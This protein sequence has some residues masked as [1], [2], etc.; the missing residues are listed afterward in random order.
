MQR[1]LL[2][3]IVLASLLP[4]I[5][6]SA[7]KIEFAEGQLHA[8][9]RK[10]MVEGDRKGAIALY[11]QVLASAMG[12]RA[13]AARALIRLGQCYE[14]LGNAEARKAYERVVKEFSDQKDASEAQ[15]LLAALGGGADRETV[16]RI[17]YSA[18]GAYGGRNSRDGRYVAFEC[19]RAICLLETATGSIR[20]VVPEPKPSARHWQPLPSPDGNWVAYTHFPNHALEGKGDLHV[21]RTDGS[22]DRTLITGD[23]KL[24]DYF[25]PVDW[26]ADSKTILTA[27]TNEKW[28]GLMLVPVAVGPVK[29]LV[30]P[31]F[32][33]FAGRDSAKF[34]PGGE[35]IAY[36]SAKPENRRPGSTETDVNVMPASGGETWPVLA[37]K[38]RDEVVGWLPNGDLLLR[39]DRSGAFRPYRIQII[40]GK[41]R[42]EAEMI[43]AELGD[44]NLMGTSATNGAIFLSRSERSS[45]LYAWKPGTTE[46]RRLPLDFQGHNHYPSVSPDGK[47]LVYCVGA[48]E[49]DRFLVARNLESGEERHLPGRFA[50]VR[51]LSW[52]PDSRSL[53]VLTF[54]GDFDT[55]PT[56]WVDTVTGDMKT[57][58]TLTGVATTR[59]T[60]AILPDGKTMVLLR[61]K[62]SGGSSEDSVQK[63]DLETMSAT[64]IVQPRTEKD[65]IGSPSVSPNGRLVAYVEGNR[66]TQESWITV[67]P[68]DQAKPVRIYACK[69]IECG[70]GAPYFPPDGRTVVFERSNS[71]GAVSLWRVPVEGGEARPFVGAQPTMEAPAFNP[72]TGEVITSIGKESGQFRVVPFRALTMN[73]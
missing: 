3:A 11:E 16:D 27:K 20:T 4:A 17:L 63:L 49:R 62:R 14:K 39:S 36:P 61:R 24:H 46:P 18:P 35:W 30:T 29:E 54:A 65:T 12:N 64:A 67:S 71:A 70:V 38:G 34:S 33:W 44:W 32:E 9:I 15:A 68:I 55:R 66:E 19:N 10:E 57:F 42:G 45:D 52:Y 69:P 21:A 73:P 72:Q 59:G 58:R 47:T 43:G 40:D 1:A 37:G 60:P 51:N 56:F 28:Q 25:S 7:Q 53:L 6:L 41:P 13:V 50:G 26:T 22:E 48:N 23:T 8:A 5:R 31:D 2:A